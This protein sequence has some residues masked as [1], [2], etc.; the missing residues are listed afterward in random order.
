MLDYARLIFIFQ[1]LIELMLML[2]PAILL[3]AFGSFRNG[4]YTG[5]TSVCFSATGQSGEDFLIGGCRFEETLLDT[6]TQGQEP[7]LQFS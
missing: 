7:V 4:L 6:V 2:P 3:Q 5:W 1:Y